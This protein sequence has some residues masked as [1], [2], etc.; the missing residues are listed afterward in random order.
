[1]RRERLMEYEEKIY[2]Q[3]RLISDKEAFYENLLRP[4][5]KK[6]NGV[7]NEEYADMRR[8]EMVE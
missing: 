1:M 4:K 5:R 3:R 6:P 2:D 7:S 8:K